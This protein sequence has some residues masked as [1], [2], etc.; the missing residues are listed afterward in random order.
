MYDQGRGVAKDSVRAAV[1]LARSRELDRDAGDTSAQTTLAQ[2][3]S[4]PAN[5]GP[6]VNASSGRDPN[7]TPAVATAVSSAGPVSVPTRIKEVKPEYPI[8]ARYARTQGDVVLEVTIGTD[9]AVTKTRVVQSIPLLD[10]AAEDAVKQWRFVP[11]VVNGKPVTVTVP[12]T[13]KF[14]LSNSPSDPNAS[15]RGR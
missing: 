4:A 14:A 11:T 8:A 7:T 9:G 1:L 5:G 15:G 13:V 3:S 6:Q 12:L 2:Q 10:A